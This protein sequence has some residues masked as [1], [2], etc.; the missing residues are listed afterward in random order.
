M[1]PDQSARY[2]ARH[3]RAAHLLG[4]Y[5]S[6]AFQAA[7]LRWDS[8]NTAEAVD[9]VDCIIEAATAAALVEIQAQYAEADRHNP[10][11]LPTD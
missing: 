3:E 1:P 5:F 7:G 9:L 8:D 4:F 11:R 10:Y 6:Q 2:A